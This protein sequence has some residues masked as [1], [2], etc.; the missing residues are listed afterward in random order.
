M[1]ALGRAALW[2]GRRPGA[3]AAAAGRGAASRA[4]AGAAPPGDDDAP[5][6]S[7]PFRSLKAAAREA[8][9]VEA[10]DL[11]GSEE[12]V[13]LNVMC[14]KLG[15]PCLCRT[16]VVLGRL[17]NLRRLDLSCNRLTALPEALA[18]LPRLAFLNVAGNPL[19]PF[20]ALLREMGGLEE[21]VVDSALLRKYAAEWRRLRAGGVGVRVA[22]TG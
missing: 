8:R 1:Q 10:L 5:A 17:R 21:V 6:A 7:P 11:A 3:G 4:G 9:A 16:S 22:E 15:E 2:L 19:E 18:G 20:P 13:C 14:A 12:L